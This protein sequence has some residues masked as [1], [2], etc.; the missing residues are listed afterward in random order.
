MGMIIFADFFF[1]Y[2]MFFKKG[3]GKRQDNQG[4]NGGELRINSTHNS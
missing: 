2:A 4:K 1:C 3:N